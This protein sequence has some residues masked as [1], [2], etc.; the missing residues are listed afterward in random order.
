MSVPFSIRWTPHRAV[1]DESGD[2]ISPISC[3]QAQEIAKRIV[4]ANDEEIRSLRDH[5]AGC[6]VCSEFVAQLREESKTEGN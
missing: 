6:A 1:P 4:T 5:L 2:A 3:G